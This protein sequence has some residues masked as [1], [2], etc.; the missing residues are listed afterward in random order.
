M[1]SHST[2]STTGSMRIPSDPLSRVSSSPYQSFAPTVPGGES[3]RMFIGPRSEVSS[4]TWSSATAAI[5]RSVI[6]TRSL[7]GGSFQASG[8]SSWQPVNAS[9][10]ASTISRLIEVPFKATA[11]EIETRAC[12]AGRL[13]LRY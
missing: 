3:P 2:G 6:L 10:R 13:Y 4:G 8:S 11:A 12:R 9:S 1:S 7:S 5:A